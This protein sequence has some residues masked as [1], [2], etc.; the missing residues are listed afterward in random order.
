MASRYIDIDIFKNDNKKI[1]QKILDSRGVDSIVHHGKM[2]LNKPEIHEMASLSKI[3]HPWAS[4]DKMYKLS[5]K[6]YGKT[7]Y[8][9]LIAWFNK[10]PLDFFYRPGQ[11]VYIPV[12]LEEALYYAGKEE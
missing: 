4:G 2:R 5:D 12:P 11:I 1:Y 8:W 6:Y 10:M 7:D 9:W 3:S